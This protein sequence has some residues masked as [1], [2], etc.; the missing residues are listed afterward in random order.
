MAEGEHDAAAILS[1]VEVL[2][3]LKPDELV[4]KDGTQLPPELAALRDEGKRLFGRC[5]VQEKFGDREVKE[6]LEEVMGHRALLRKLE[7]IQK[8]IDREH[9][10]LCSESQRAAI[11]KQVCSLLLFKDGSADRPAGRRH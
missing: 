1:A 7:S 10:K 2:R 6:Y 8:K 3:R 11:N 5:I 9:D 4:E